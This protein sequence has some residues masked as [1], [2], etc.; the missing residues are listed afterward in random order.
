LQSDD[1]SYSQSLAQRKEYIF[2][3]YNAVCRLGS[4][5]KPL[6]CWY[7]EMF[8]FQVLQECFIFYNDSSNIEDK[9]TDTTPHLVVEVYL[10]F[11]LTFGTR[12]KQVASFMH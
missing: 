11:L 12:R 10:H 4:R 8:D 6:Y 5:H 3:P 2:Q 1:S 7:R 9:S